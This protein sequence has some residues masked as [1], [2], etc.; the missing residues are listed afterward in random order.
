MV[1]HP[2]PGPKPWPQNRLARHVLIRAPQEV[3]RVT[4]KTALAR[5]AVASLVGW[6]PTLHANQAALTG[7]VVDART[8]QPL[9]HVLV[10]IDQHA[11]SVETGRDGRFALDLPP[12]RYT[13]SASLI[14]YASVRQVVDVA[15]GAS[16]DLIIEL[17]EGAGIYEEHV[18]VSGAARPEAD[19]APAGAVLYGREL[20]ALRGVMLDDPLRAV[21]ALPAATSTDD[22]YSEFA[23]RGN[24][25][26]HVGLII[27]GI[28][29][30]YLIHSIHAATDG[31][32][33]AMVNSEAL[34]SVS[35]L[36][37]SYPQRAGRRLGA[38]LDLATR[39]GSRDAFH[40]RAGASG[41]SAF[42]IGEG[43]LGGGRGAWL[44]SA[45]RSYLDFLLERIDPDG[46]FGFGF[47]DLLTKVTFDL[48]PRHQFQVL[49]V[50]GRSVFDEEAEGLGPN[51]DALA[52]SRAWL[53]SATWRFTPAARLSVSQR[54]YVT[55][56]DYRNVNSNDV[57]LDRGNANDLGWR[58]DVTFALR[59]GWI[60]EFG[61]DMQ[62][63]T[64]GHARYR[65]FD[66]SADP[67]RI[68]D[69]T[70]AARSSSAY[71]QLSA[72]L[73]AVTVA[74]GGR[75]DY[76]QATRTTTSS[77]W[78]TAELSVT[79]QTRLRGGAGIYRQPPSLAQLNGINGNAGLD[80]E[81]AIHTDITLIRS[82]PQS[83]SV[84]VTGFN[85][86]EADVLRAV[87]AEARRR[88]DGAIE[89]GRGDAR[90]ANRLT[91]RA[92]G[93]EAVVRR[94]AP[95]G[96]SGWV[97]YAFAKHH[98]DD[99]V[100]GERFWSDADQRHTFSAYGSYRLSN[101]TSVGAKFRY[102]S[103]YPI[104]GYVGEQRMSPAAPPLFG[105]QRPLFYSLTDVRN[106]LRLPAYARLDIRADRVVSVAGRRVMLFAEVANALNRR[107][108]RNVPYSVERNGRIAG[109]TDSL[110]P[111]V[112]SAGL[113][114]E[115]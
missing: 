22:F 33:I 90:W 99:T 36:P 103:N 39:D 43:P 70:A 77:P 8:Q 107:N 84:Q 2:S 7:R 35:L 13:L 78:I 11:T 25:F 21:Q 15:A 88:A 110:M 109:V 68:D 10:Q 1:R 30:P 104:T 102:G 38:Q 83:T 58:T 27:D 53:S 87:G 96:L 37:G 18:T 56:M 98:Y 100:T 75:V 69:Y 62:R 50:L 114:I 4:W 112:P 105:G 106:T 6:Q 108:E 16:P 71:A 63:S 81:K 34:G 47:S 97:A 46:N 73:G 41:T 20:Q 66:G 115:F 76:W 74:P 52:A 60:A 48:S 29:S 51:D 82:L 72:R 9:A 80:P 101:R 64:S 49:T 65:T 55:G 44:V 23:V 17:S 45:R 86:G 42:F 79:A 95:S 89:L 24:G 92:R 54:V 5:F 93:V 19:K 61:G 91:G 85:R 94:D 12:G 111:I 26:R 32:S 113:V 57:V 14:G 67:T 59:D 3:S 28:P 31:G 40:G